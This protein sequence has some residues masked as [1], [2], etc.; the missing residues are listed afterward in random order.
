MLNFGGDGGALPDFLFLFYFPC[1]AGRKRDGSLC[2]VVFASYRGSVYL[3][4]YVFMKAWEETKT[5]LSS[6]P[7][8]RAVLLPT[9]KLDHNI[10]HGRRE[11]TNV[12]EKDVYNSTTEVSIAGRDEF[13]SPLKNNRARSPTLPD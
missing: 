12:D 11:M 9:A 13:R 6:L 2:M 7:M 10:I 1:S 8:L 4:L 3:M 5:M